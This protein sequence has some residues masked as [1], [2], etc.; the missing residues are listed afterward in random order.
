MLLCDGRVVRRR[1]KLVNALAIYLVCCLWDVGGH[2]L[3]SG[4]AVHGQQRRQ[5]RWLLVGRGSQRGRA[6]ALGEAVDD[7]H[8]H[9]ALTAWR[10]RRHVYHT[11]SYHAAYRYEFSCLGMTIGPR[12]GAGAAAVCRPPSAPKPSTS[13]RTGPSRP[14]SSRSPRAR[15][16]GTG[17]FLA[18][19]APRESEKPPAGFGASP[20]EAITCAKYQRYCKEGVIKVSQPKG[21]GQA[22]GSRQVCDESVLGCFETSRH[23]QDV[24]RS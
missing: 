22:V 20:P 3:G 8:W 1:L 5:Q 15:A 9:A 19:A 21:R 16:R 14:A 13:S 2:E 17:G 4:T 7:W 23:V 18:A 11:L 10:L 24:Q 12:L 6:Q